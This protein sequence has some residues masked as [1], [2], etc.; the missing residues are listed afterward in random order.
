M[1]Y[2]VAINRIGKNRKNVL[3]LIETVSK[4]SDVDVQYCN[5]SESVYV[6]KV[7]NDL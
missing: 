4:F 7:I 3:Q 1:V 2:K 6:Q 5:Y